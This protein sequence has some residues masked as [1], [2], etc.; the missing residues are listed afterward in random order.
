MRKVIEELNGEA[1]TVTKRQ[2][3]EVT[4]LAQKNSLDLSA[5]VVEIEPNEIT[6]FESPNQKRVDRIVTRLQR[7]RHDGLPWPEDVPLVLVCKGGAGNYYLQ[8]GHHRIAAARWIGLRPI[9]ALAVDCKTVEDL[10]K[11]FFR[12]GLQMTIWRVQEVLAEFDPLMRKNFELSVE[13][14]KRKKRARNI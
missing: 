3:E 8:D 14:E 2:A 5:H 6:M 9:P 7:A 1:V 11:S 12:G 10:M 13:G 4:A